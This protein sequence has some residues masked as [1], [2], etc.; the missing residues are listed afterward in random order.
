MTLHSATRETPYFIAFEVEV[1][2]PIEIGLLSYRTTHFL[3]KGNEKGLRL[4]L[5]LLE[6]RRKVENLRAAA[7]KQCSAWYYNLTE[8]SG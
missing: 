6:E 7:Y 5:E 1:V 2:V 8:H 4:E 3:Y